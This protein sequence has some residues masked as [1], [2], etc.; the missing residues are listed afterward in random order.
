LI[1]DLL[2]DSTIYEERRGNFA[3]ARSVIEA[4]LARGRH[5]DPLQHADALFA[6]G[7]VQM[8]QGELSA[9][10]RN[11]HEVDALSA[12]NPVRQL[13]TRVYAWHAAMID[14]NYFPNGG[15]ASG[16]DINH[17]GGMLAFV[18]ASQNSINFEELLLQVSDFEALLERRL[19]TL[20]NLTMM[21]RHPALATISAARHMREVAATSVKQFRESIAIERDDRKTL[22]MLDRDIAFLLVGTG[23]RETGIKA[24]RQSQLAF[25]QL[26][27]PV[28]AANCL[29]DVGDWLVA[30]FGGPD[31]WNSALSE[32]S[33]SH[34][35]RWEIE[36]A[37]IDP[38][39]I[40]IGQARSVYDQARQSYHD[41]TALRGLAAIE[42]RYGYMALLDTTGQP[43]VRERHKRAAQH[44]LKARDYF[45]QAGDHLGYQLATAHYLLC[46]VGIGK[47][48]EDQE[49][50]ESIGDWG[51]SNGSFSYSLGLGILFARIGRRWLLR[52]G[53]FERSLN[54]FHLSEA[55]FRGLGAQLSQV[56]SAMDQAEVYV[57]LGE[58]DAFTVTAERALTLCETMLRGDT[59]QASE[60]W[61]LAAWVAVQLKQV[62]NRNAD[63]NGI[64]LAADRMK[65][66]MERF[67]LTPGGK[68]ANIRPHLYL[69]LASSGQAVA[70]DADPEQ[71]GSL[72]QAGMLMWDIRNSAF[73][74]PL[75]RG[76]MA[77]M[78]GDDAGARLSFEQA[79]E[80]ARAGAGMDPLLAEAHVLAYQRNE[81]AAVA[82]L[83]TYYAQRVAR[84]SQPAG[85]SELW[86]D[87]IRATHKEA[88][89]FYCRLRSF[90]DA[91]GHLEQLT[92]LDGENWWTI[93]GPT[94]DNLSLAAEVYEGLRRWTESL[95]FY[96]KAM[97]IYNEQRKLLSTDELKTA[98]AGSS[99]SQ[100]MYLNAARAMLKARESALAEGHV[101]VARSLLAAAFI[102]IERGKARSLIDLMADS[103][104]ASSY[105][106]IAPEQRRWRR[107]SAFVASRRRLLAHEHSKQDADHGRIKTLGEE[108]AKA[109]EERRKIEIHLFAEDEWLNR[110]KMASTDVLGCEGVQALLQPGTVLLQYAFSDRE[111]IAW[112]I[113]V[114]CVRVHRSDFPENSLRLQVRAFH[115]ACESGK[116][117]DDLARNL[118]VILLAPFTDIIDQSRQLIIVPSGE[119]YLLPF[120]ALPWRDQPLGSSRVVTYLPSSSAM[121]FSRLT[122]R[123]TRAPRVLAI[124]NP[125]NMS[126]QD[127]GHPTAQTFSPLPAAETEAVYVASLFPDGKALTGAD[128][129][130]AAV[131]SEISSYTI[132]H[133]ATHGHLSAT[134]PLQSA[135]LLANGK[136]LTVYD[137]MG[138]HIDADL[139]V[140]SACRT[141]QG[142]TTRGDDVLG[143]T[144]ALL[145]TGA[146]A[147]VVSLWQVDDLATSILMGEFYRQLRGGEQ[148]IKSLMAAQTYLRTCTYAHAKT[149]LERL[150][151]LAGDNRIVGE[152]VDRAIRY[153]GSRDLDSPRD[154]HGLA[155]NH[156]HFWAAFVLI[157]G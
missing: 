123:Q 10:R 61:G 98:I 21:G 37:E 27:D 62:A 107:Q 102:A 136:A 60:A 57:V 48:I 59:S 51:R 42:I 142:E 80:A 18:L 103:A 140:L 94:W 118:S 96:D 56:H 134:A 63:P 52:D 115:K 53:D 137:L 91:A 40:D 70:P 149:E 15:T 38:S 71:T 105:K 112:M 9:A 104:I 129:T 54:C 65:G 43:D 4:H 106:D 121:Q 19:F 95:T 146:R 151:Q 35:L 5:D 83:R 73:T 30:P 155:Y 125:A 150:R 154:A 119:A 20:R 14:R 122:P 58:R 93:D 157:G 23:Q 75:Y 89:I 152:T 131:R 78:N 26:G 139:V 120:H 113:T 117:T 11:F 64:E 109:E 46:R 31:V 85:P 141:G 88:L 99:S 156:P 66:L 82:K 33:Y 124:G 114:D 111:L 145:A 68:L 22:A 39:E 36:A 84:L 127:V 153:M 86:Q 92:K 87:M 108:L 101:T 13:R 16:K 77:R 47:Y 81:V 7:I 24:L 17:S 44:A 67:G 12:G 133:F 126:Y 97:E 41:S 143:L 8:L 72:A 76:R 135:V 116:V 130:D 100:Y 110:R 144:R 79:L 147:V 25:E 128:A 55:L 148:P 1:G 45:E 90:E 74:A 28:G 49:V 50:A 29:V 34:A 6:L 138:F 69:Q 2:G 132:L 32:S 3:D